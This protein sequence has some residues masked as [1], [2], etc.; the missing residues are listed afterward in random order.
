MLWLKELY[1]SE[2]A[3]QK[4]KNLVRA[5][6]GGRKGKKDSCWLITLS[7]Y[8]QGQLDLFKSSDLESKLFDTRQMVVLGIARDKQDGLALLEKMTAECLD[9]GG[10]AGLRAYFA[11]KATTDWRGVKT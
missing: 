11:A 6:E 8:P 9:K 3:R 4:G 7:V 1:W 2:K 10:G 5:A